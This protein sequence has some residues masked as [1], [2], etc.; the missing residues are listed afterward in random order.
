MRES[1][2]SLHGVEMKTFSEFQDDML[3]HIDLGEIRVGKREKKSPSMLRKA[4]LTYRKIRNKVKMKMRKY[5]KTSKYKKTQRL[6]KRMA[7]KGMTST[8]RQITVRGGQGAEQRR[9]ER[10]KEIRK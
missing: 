6:S 3:E 8:G 1:V 5:R 2:K 7:R 9:K 4:R 10:Q